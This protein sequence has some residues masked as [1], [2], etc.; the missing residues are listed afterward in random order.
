[1]KLVVGLGNPGPRYARTRHNAGFRVAECF[2]ARHAIELASERFG[3]RFGR[4]RI[5]DDADAADDVAPVVA[6]SSPAPSA[7]SAS[8]AARTPTRSTSACRP[9]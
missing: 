8:G 3:G 9:R 7:S 2:A 1:V 5:A 4:G 6:V